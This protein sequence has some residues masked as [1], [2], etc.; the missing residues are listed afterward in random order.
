M[1]Y[2]MEGKEPRLEEEVFVADGS[3]IIGNVKIEYGASIWFNSVI[4]GDLGPIKIG[5][6]TNIQENSTLHV[7]EGKPLTI[8]NYV[9]VGHG[10]ILHGC[11][12]KDNC[13][14]GMGSTILNDAVVG[15][16]SIIG[17]G[18]LLPENK[19]IPPNSLVMGVPGRVR[20]EITEKEIEEIKK[21][22]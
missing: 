12:V 3:K 13:L 15:E 6:K 1:I 5:S 21:S 10:A 20:R 7:D 18:T 4:R 8:G 9:T 16:N 11:T 19:I 17:A 22:A 2:E 14:I